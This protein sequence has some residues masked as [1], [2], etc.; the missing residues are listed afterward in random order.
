MVH[1]RLAALRPNGRNAQIDAFQRI[2]AIVIHKASPTGG[3]REVGGMKDGEAGFLYF[4]DLVFTKPDMHVVPT[5]DEARVAGNGLPHVVHHPVTA[6][7]QTP[8][9]QVGSY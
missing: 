7:E 8:P 9:Y 1:R 4:E 2:E 6:G 3:V 5:E